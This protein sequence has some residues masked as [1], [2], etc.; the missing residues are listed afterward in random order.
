MNYIYLYIYINKVY[1][2]FIF[3]FL[4]I[5]EINPC[6]LVHLQIF[7]PILRVIFLILFTVSFAVQNLLSLIRFHLFILVFISTTLEAGS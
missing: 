3:I 5:L 6:Q 7:F 4:Y 2:I 1:F